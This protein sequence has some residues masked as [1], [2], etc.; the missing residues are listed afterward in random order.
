MEIFPRTQAGFSLGL[1]IHFPLILLGG[2]LFSALPAQATAM[3]VE[4]KDHFH[5]A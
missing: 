2:F 3:D 5:G 4:K 1:P